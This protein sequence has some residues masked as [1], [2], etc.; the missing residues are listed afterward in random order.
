M[1][2]RSIQP[3]ASDRPGVE[4]ELAAAGHDIDEQVTAARA[5]RDA[6]IFAAHRAGRDDPIVVRAL[7]IGRDRG[8]EADRQRVPSGDVFRVGQ[9][10]GGPGRL[11]ESRRRQASREQSANDMAHRHFPLFGGNMTGTRF[12]AKLL[13]E[14]A[15]FI[16]V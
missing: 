4:F 15:Y 11:G 5:E 12:E 6:V 7:V 13:L 2:V 10:A 9:R 14:N 3:D 1:W 8:A 16:E